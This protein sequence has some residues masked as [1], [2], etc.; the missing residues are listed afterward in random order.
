MIPG[1]NILHAYEYIV[2]V[3]ADRE[4]W[5]MMSMFFLWGS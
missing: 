4:H 5:R 2:N 3:I 1:K